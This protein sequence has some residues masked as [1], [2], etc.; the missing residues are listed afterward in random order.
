[1]VRLFDKGAGGSGI[2]ACLCIL[3]PTVCTVTEEAAG[4]Y[5][6]Y[7]EHPEDEYG[8]FKMLAEYMIIEAPVP[9]NVIPEIEL[10]PSEILSVSTAADFWK[11]LPQYKN[12]GT[13][14]NATIKKIRE[15]PAMYQWAP[16]RG[17]SAGSYCVYNGGI[18][19]TSEFTM[20]QI[21]GTSGS[22]WRFV[23]TLY[24]G[25]GGSSQPGTYIAGE[26]YSPGLSVGDVV[27]KEADYNAS[28]SQIKDA[29][30]RV[31]YILKNALTLQT[32]EE[33]T[34]PEQTIETQFFRIYKVYSDDEP[35]IV[36]VCARHISYDF[37]GNKIMDCAFQDAEPVNAI[38]MMQG[39]LMYE[40]DR[41]IACQ[42]ASDEDTSYKITK[43]WSFKNPINALLNNDEGIVPALDAKLIRNNKDF[44]ILQDVGIDTG[45][46]LEYGNNLRGVNWTRNTE[47]VI[48]RV[49][50]R[51]QTEDDDYLYLEHGGTWDDDYFNEWI[52]NDEIYVN[53]PH[54]SELPYPVIEILDCNFK[55]GEK[56]TPHDSTQ[57]ITRTI[58]SCREDMLKEAQKRFT[59][60]RCDGIEIALEVDFILLGDTEEYKQYKGLQRLNLYDFVN[61]KNKHF[62]IQARMTGY[63][64]DSIKMRYNAVRVGNVNAFLRRIPGFR[65]VKES[66]TYDKLA[67]G[68]IQQIRTM[69]AGE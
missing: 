40:D 37:A 21:P 35:G 51:C 14:T 56:Y 59:E 1:M 7:M 4:E 55:V 36:K 15:N 8:K 44:Y 43:D 63:E 33:V 41:Q 54:E 18:Y 29:L 3:D 24:G 60:D 31:G 42:F 49:I 16:S 23:D 17:F 19:Q 52:Q 50:P 67:P 9:K 58:A 13:D 30:G 48:S 68:L 66:I 69:R 10:P 47:P 5:E 61:V 2:D 53:S 27:T 26:K 28:Y 20:N 11:K 25:G 32:T 64:F 45:I 12:T 6:L 22:P 39:K 57:E 38:A 62:T 65:M 46:T 34:I